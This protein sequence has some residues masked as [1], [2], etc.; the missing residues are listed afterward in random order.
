RF[1]MRISLGY[2]DAAAEKQLFL[3][4]DPRQHLPNLKVC[5]SPEQLQEV[6]AAVQQIKTSD[7]LLDYLQ[8]LIHYTRV[9][10]D[11]TF[12]LSPRG[13]MALLRAAKTWAY[14]HGRAYVIPED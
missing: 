4:G 5:L 2:P 1:L 7:N 3:G 11:F 6:K 10:S 8:R 12:G 9:S 14:M 13:A